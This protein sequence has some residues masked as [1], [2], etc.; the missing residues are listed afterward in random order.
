MYEYW[1]MCSHLFCSVGVLPF[2][3]WLFVVFCILPSSSYSLSHSL[4]FSVIHRTGAIGKVECI[5]GTEMVIT[6]WISIY[7]DMIVVQREQNRKKIW[8][9]KF[10]SE[11]RIYFYFVSIQGGYLFFVQTEFV[12]GY[13]HSKQMLCPDF[14]SLLRSLAILNGKLSLEN[15]YG[16]HHFTFVKVS[17]TLIENSIPCG[18]RRLRC[19]HYYYS[20]V[21]L[22]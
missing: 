21:F 10:P 18:F 2:Y 1:A 15:F 16:R 6:T 13:L 8:T 17:H 12:N 4:Q 9:W 7:S 19:L 3:F 20:L 5:Y 11:M 14:V 22:V